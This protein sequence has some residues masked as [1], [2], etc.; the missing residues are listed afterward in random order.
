MTPWPTFFLTPLGTWTPADAEADIPSTKQVGDVCDNWEEETDGANP[1][2]ASMGD[3]SV[4]SCLL[5]LGRSLSVGSFKSHPRNEI[6][7]SRH[8]RPVGNSHD[9]PLGVEHL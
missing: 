1:A 9:A 6:K 7:L 3:S 2:S 8:L 4:I 5:W